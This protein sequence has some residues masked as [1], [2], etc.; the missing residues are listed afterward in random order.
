MNNTYRQLH[1]LNLER[2]KLLDDVKQINKE[3]ARIKKECVHEYPNE[4]FLP[5][6]GRK[7]Y[8]CNNCCEAKIEYPEFGPT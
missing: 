6:D 1:D 3:I 4:P 7:I 5:P 8:V 2:R